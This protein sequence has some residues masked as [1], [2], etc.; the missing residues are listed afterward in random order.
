M[1]F[2]KELLDSLLYTF[3]FVTANEV[4]DMIEKGNMFV[5]KY[6]CW[7]LFLE[8][9]KTL[10]KGKA[11]KFQSEPQL[12]KRKTKLTFKKCVGLC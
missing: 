4:V 11:P 9:H 1:K 8:Y 3:V 12:K 6:K 5:D 2:D 7:T 10:Y